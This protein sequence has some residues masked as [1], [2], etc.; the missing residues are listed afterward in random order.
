MSVMISDAEFYEYGRVA[1]TREMK[2]NVLI[3]S[4]LFHFPLINTGNTQT[5]TASYSEKVTI[6][7][8]FLKAISY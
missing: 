7:H 6:G 5:N 8:I 4:W 2:I 3:S 1:K